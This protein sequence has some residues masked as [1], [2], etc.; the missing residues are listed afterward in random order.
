M[1]FSFTRA[2]QRELRSQSLSTIHEATEP[3]ETEPESTE[4]VTEPEATEPETTESVTE[5]E[6]TEPTIESV[7]QPEVLHFGE[8]H[9]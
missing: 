8:T 1:V 4:S 6:A 9:A 2:L 3:T 7:T 5:S